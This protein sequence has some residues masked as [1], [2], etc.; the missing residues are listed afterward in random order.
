M[1]EI[2]EPTEHEKMEGLGDFVLAI[3]SVVK[4][5]EQAARTTRTSPESILRD[6]QAAFELRGLKFIHPVLKN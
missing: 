2:R 1:T 6:T 5:V 4:A 3:G